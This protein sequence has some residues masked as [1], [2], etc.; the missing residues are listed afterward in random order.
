MPKDPQT[1]RIYF[2]FKGATDGSAF[3][4]TPGDAVPYGTIKNVR[5]K[6]AIGGRMRGGQRPAVRQVK[7]SAGTAWG[8]V[9][10][11]P[12][13]LITSMAV[14]SRITGYRPGAAI[15]SPDA[16]ENKPSAANAGDVFLLRNSSDY[17][18]QSRALSVPTSAFTNGTRNITDLCWTSASQVF[19]LANDNP[20]GANHEAFRFHADFAIGDSNDGFGA[21]PYTTYPDFLSGHYPGNA[22]DC[23]PTT[24]GILDHYVFAAITDDV[25]ATPPIPA[26]RPFGYVV[27]YNVSDQTLGN[28]ASPNCQV[29]GGSQ[30]TDGLQGAWSVKDIKC[31]ARDSGGPTGYYLY[32][33]YVAG[34]QSESFIGRY[35]VT[36]LAS[37]PDDTVFSLDTPGAGAFQIDGSTFAADLND[38]TARAVNYPRGAIPTSVAVDS[39]GMV[40]F[41]RGSTGYGPTDIPVN[42]PDYVGS[43]PV[44][45]CKV[46]PYPA[47]DTYGFIWESS[48]NVNPAEAATDRAAYPELLFC[49]ADDTGVYAGGRM[50]G[51]ASLFKLRTEDGGPAWNTPWFHST[52]N[53]AAPT[54]TPSL[55]AAAFD[56][57]GHIIVVGTRSNTWSGVTSGRYANIWK[58]DA[59]SGATIW[60]YDLHDDTSATGVDALSISV[61]ATTGQIA[62]GTVHTA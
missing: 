38:T 3:I 39:D 53:S 37:F 41:T 6:D 16:W 35:N 44:T 4:E 43:V 47:S 40:Y 57:D 61:N 59:S 5:P 27:A 9:G 26:N 42:R 21:S 52:S 46:D 14:P 10:D 7:D 11:G 36:A 2:P 25:T 58:V 30:I 13:D 20:V 12:I 23:F 15:Q 54:L 24:G 28:S 62:V 8:R 34:I 17:P 32:F 22:V 56:V 31:M 33:C 50:V 45:V 19:G 18:F 55:Y 51:G 48:T 60:A 49:L 29:T 1:P